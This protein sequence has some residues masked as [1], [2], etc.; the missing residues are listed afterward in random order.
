ML[1]CIDTGKITGRAHLKKSS[2]NSR[3]MEKHIS[4][5]PGLFSEKEFLIFFS[6]NVFDSLD[7]FPAELCQRIDRNISR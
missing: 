2:R 6:E 5:I 7:F 3:Q 4:T 1:K